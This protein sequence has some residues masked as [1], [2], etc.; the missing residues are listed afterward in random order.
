MFA[1]LENCILSN[2]NGASKIRFMNFRYYKQEKPS[3]KEPPNLTVTEIEGRI[4]CF[5]RSSF[6][7]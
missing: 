6:G 4:S 5:D 7:G 3:Y 2:Y 1:E